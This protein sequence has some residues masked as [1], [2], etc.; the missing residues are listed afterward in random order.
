MNNDTRINNNV[1]N[2]EANPLFTR[3]QASDII[4]FNS[5]SAVQNNTPIWTPGTGKRIFLTAIQISSLG[6]LTVTLNR[7]NNLPF[8][9]INLTTAFATYS[10]SFSS[11]LKF[12][13][14]EAISL[15]TSTAV[16]VNITLL[17][18]EG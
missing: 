7:N 13:P 2:Y 3:E 5:F 18:Y 12:A 6:A 4:L 15:R 1:F 8:L 17:G 16:T 14:G 10:E 9:S 11:P